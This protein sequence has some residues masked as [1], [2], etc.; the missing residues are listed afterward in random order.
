MRDLV[1]E[2][3]IEVGGQKVADGIIRRLENIKVSYDLENSDMFAI[4][5]NDSDFKIQNSKIFELGKEVVVK[6]GYSQ[7]Y[8]KMIEGEIVRLDFS[9]DSGEPMSVTVIGFD[10]MFR[11]NRTKQTRS[12]LKKTDSQIAKQIANEMGLKADIDNTTQ[13]FDYVFQNNQS[14]LN[15]LK[16]RAKRIDY[17]VEVEDNTLIFKKNRVNKRKKSVRLVWD[18]NLI[19]FHPKI[20]ATK[21]VEEI[22]VKGWDAKTKKV[23]KVKVKAG[24]EDRAIDGIQGSKEIKGKFKSSWN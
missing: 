5:L 21:I 9:Y 7:K 6:L 16:Q 19:S 22:E 17:E 24:E 1:P 14:N 18:R 3:M 23:I 11:L 12:F 13:K 8:T 10:K 2:A 4:T 15:F 20:D